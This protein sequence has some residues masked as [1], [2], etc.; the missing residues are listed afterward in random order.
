MSKRGIPG[1]E[2]T[3]RERV[4]LALWAVRDGLPTVARVLEAST[5]ATAYWISGRSSPQIAARRRIARCVKRFEKREAEW[6]ERT[7]STYQ[8]E[9]AA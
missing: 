6:I 2:I 4:T 9:R 7:L 5:V 3:P 1:V 8:T